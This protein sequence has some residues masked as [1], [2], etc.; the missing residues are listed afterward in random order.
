MDSKRHTQWIT[1]SF[2]NQDI[3]LNVRL[4]VTSSIEPGEVLVD[5]VRLT[6]GI[7]PM[8]IGLITEKTNILLGDSTRCIGGH[9]KSLLK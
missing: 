4:S 9:M 7:G 8:F 5:T 2:I 1:Y 3:F 6:S